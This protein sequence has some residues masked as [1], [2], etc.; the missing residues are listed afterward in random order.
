[1]LL[2]LISHHLI[3]IISCRGHTILG[4]I[5]ESMLL[6]S[7]IDVCLLVHLFSLQ[8]GANIN[9]SLMTL[10]KVISGLSD[11]SLNPKKKVFIPY[12]D[13]VLTWYVWWF[14]LS[15][16]NGGGGGGGGVITPLPPAYS[17]SPPP[18]LSLSVW[19]TNL[20]GNFVVIL[21]FNLKRR[22]S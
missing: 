20:H 4:Q 19:D 15:L 11:K 3:Q 7:S 14:Y 22:G 6:H 1:M 5:T 2:L 16:H 8:E 21:S 12:R 17:L 18:S 13:S 10:G 9:R